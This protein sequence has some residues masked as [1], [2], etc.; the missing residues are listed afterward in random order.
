MPARVHSQ[1][2]CQGIFIISFYI[3]F[4][5]FIVLWPK[6]KELIMKGL[7][8]MNLATMYKL[9]KARLA[10]HEAA[11]QH[12]AVTTWMVQEAQYYLDFSKALN[13]DNRMCLRYSDEEL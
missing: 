1:R 2:H 9:F 5:L 10:G 13:E 12:L 7:A 8:E 3:L 11:C 4:G 6:H